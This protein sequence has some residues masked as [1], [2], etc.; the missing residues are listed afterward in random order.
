MTGAAPRWGFVTTNKGAVQILSLRYKRLKGF[1]RSSY[2]VRWLQWFGKCSDDILLLRPCLHPNRY[3]YSLCEAS[4]ALNRTLWKPRTGSATPHL[5]GHWPL[6]SL[7]NFITAYSLH[8]WVFTG[9]QGVRCTVMIPGNTVFWWLFSSLLIM[10]MHFSNVKIQQ[11]VHRAERMPFSEVPR[12]RA[13]T[14][15]LIWFKFSSVDYVW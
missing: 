12:D 1:F 11:T 7:Q 15:M 5:A 6:P 13:K 8:Q 10:T 9:E 4:T 2:W 14:D 3:T